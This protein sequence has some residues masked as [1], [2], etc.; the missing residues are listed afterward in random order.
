M[1]TRRRTRR[2]DALF[3]GTSLRPVPPGES[4]HK[5]VRYVDIRQDVRARR[6]TAAAERAGS[7]RSR[8]SRAG[9]QATRTGWLEPYPARGR[10]PRQRRAAGRFFSTTLQATQSNYLNPHGIDLVAN[11]SS[12][13]A[14]LQQAL[15]LLATLSC[16]LFA[17]AAL[18]INIVEHPARMSCGTE[19]AVTEWVPSYSRATWMQAPLAVSAFVCAAGAWLAGST[20]WWLV[21]GVML[22][23][24]VLF[25][26]VFMMPTNKLLMSSSLDRGSDEARMLMVR[27]NR[28]HGVRT[29][30]GVVA[31]VLFLMIM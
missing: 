2:L 24:V 31:L 11:R 6:S 30:L 14:T 1:E 27:W 20:V 3:R 16:A 17:G 4:K 29:A 21:G 25:T 19:A 13:M 5:E 26:L 9:R 22:G 18:Y 7:W 15:E 10:G 12:T 23:L 28:L 8:P